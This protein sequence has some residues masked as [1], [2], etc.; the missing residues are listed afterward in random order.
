MK[1]NQRLYRINVPVDTHFVKATCAEVDCPNYVNGWRLRWDILTEE[2]RH[3]ATHA[4]R[5]YQLIEVSELEHWLVFE[6]GQL[7]FR[8]STH[9][10]RIDKPENFIVK[11]GRA[12]AMTH[13]R[14][15]DWVDDLHNHTDRIAEMR[16][17]G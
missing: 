6:P 9:K 17:A 14:I 12:P 11:D 15:D 5:K 16:E 7:C 8:E 3:T 1:A 10:R 4:G 13:T 2:Q